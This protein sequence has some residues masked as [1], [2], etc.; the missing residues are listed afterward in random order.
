ML[1]SMHIRVITFPVW[2]L[3]LVIGEHQGPLS[4]RSSPPEQLSACTWSCPETFP[5]REIML[6]LEM[7]TISQLRRKRLQLGCLQ[8]LLS[9]ACLWGAT[10][11]PMHCNNSSLGINQKASAKHMEIALKQGHKEASLGLYRVLSWLFPL[12]FPLLP[13]WSN[14]ACLNLPCLREQARFFMGQFHCCI[15]S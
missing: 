10:S 12:A 3:A 1:G 11:M 8:T 13:L 4:F 7:K 5:T 6:I 2:G 14:T 9:S 15:C